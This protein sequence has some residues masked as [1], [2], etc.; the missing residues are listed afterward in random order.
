MIEKTLILYVSDD[1]YA[2]RMLRFMSGHRQLG[3]RFE[4]VTERED[5]WQRRKREAGTENMY[6][7]TDDREGCLRDSHG[8]DHRI[9]LTEESDEK[10]H[11]VSFCICADLMHREIMKQI[12]IADVT[13]VEQG[14]P[15]VGIYAVFSP[16]GEEAEV[17]A[18]LLTQE[19]AGYGDCAYVNMNAFPHYYERGLA[20]EKHS[21]GE[22]F[23]RIEGDNY[24]MLV[25]E[26]GMPYGGAVRLPSVAHYR[27]LWD[28]NDIDRRLFL[29]R[30]NGDCH[31]PYIVVV[32][33]DIREAVPMVTYVTRFLLIIRENDP[34]ESLE[35]WKKYIKTEK[36][37]STDSISRA[38]MPTG[39]TR[40]IDELAETAPGEWLRDNEKKT[41]AAGLWR[42]EGF[43]GF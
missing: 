2:R 31:I 32:F 37:D 33:N 23:F 27:D 16:Y 25:R 30:L 15:P 41:F 29:E 39:W 13:N 19:L 10:K 35:R 40:W 14:A 20:T 43:D 8:Y 6:W 42:E 18:A 34:D 3:V 12:G 1:E 28:I 9:L 4:R 24:S 5:F 11:Q 17:S 26:S 38:V 21:L 36:I 7:I 22:L